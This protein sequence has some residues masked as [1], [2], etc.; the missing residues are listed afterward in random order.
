VGPPG[1]DRLLAPELAAAAGL[2][3]DGTVVRAAEREV[4]ALA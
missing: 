2:V 4:G 3:T 1:P